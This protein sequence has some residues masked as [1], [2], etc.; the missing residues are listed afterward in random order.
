MGSNKF[1]KLLN[2]LFDT[3]IPNLQAYPEIGADF[4]VQKVSSLEELRM[5]EMIT[6]K[7]PSD[8]SIRAYNDRDYKLLYLLKNSK[9]TLL[10]IKQH[11]QLYFDLR[12]IL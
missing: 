2:T 1:E 8:S 10:A 4:L 6:H 3:I 7:L 9:I 11:K 5:I 12:E